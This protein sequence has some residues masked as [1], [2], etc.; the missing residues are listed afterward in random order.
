MG[1]SGLCTSWGGF[2]LDGF[3]D[4]PSLVY[5]QEKSDLSR[6][7]FTPNLVQSSRPIHSSYVVVVVIY[8]V[9]VE[10]IWLLVIGHTDPPCSI[11]KEL[12]WL[13]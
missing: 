13:D 10:V 11:C 2:V 3:V 6:N 12:C 5:A 4:A 8:H 1:F 9:T 7:S